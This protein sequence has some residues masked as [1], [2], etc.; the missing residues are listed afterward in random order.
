MNNKVKNNINNNNEDGEIFLQ[1][2]TYV[3][4][5]SKTKSFNSSKNDI[6]LPTSNKADMTSDSRL[7][8][9][10][11]SNQ[12]R[13]DSDFQNRNTALEGAKRYDKPVS[14]NPFRKSSDDDW[15]SKTDLNPM[16]MKDGI[17]PDTIDSNKGVKN[18]DNVL[19]NINGGNNFSKNNN[20]NSKDGLSDRFN[21]L[22][23]NNNFN[24]FDKNDNLSNDNSSSSGSNLDNKP[25][26]NDI[27]KS[28]DSKNKPNANN[29]V[30][31]LQN[32][33]AKEALKK[34]A[35]AVN[36]ALGAIANTKVGD[37]LMDV[38]LNKAKKNL[39]N[40]NGF[41]INNLI[42]GSGNKDSDE[43]EKK[44]NA[45]SGSFVG[46][47]VLTKKQKITLLTFAGTF[48]LIM[49]AVLLI[50]CIFQFDSVKTAMQASGGMD[51][52][53]NESSNN[54]SSNSTS[55]GASGSSSTTVDNDSDYSDQGLKDLSPTGNA[56]IDKI[57][58]L[59]MKQLGNGPEKYSSNYDNWCADFVCWLFKKVEGADKLLIPASSA[60]PIPRES[61]PRGLGTWIEDECTD[62]NAV[63]KAGDI[64]HWKEADPAFKVDKYSSKHVGYVYKVDDD[65][66]YTV[67]GNGG[68]YYVSTYKKSRKD[69]NI[70]GY[71]RPYY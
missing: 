8:D 11:L 58:Q 61:I 49:M 69:C 6:D 40:L 13:G 60:G 15:T 65:Y 35:V 33:A 16:D 17:V 34:G 9:T 10:Q 48:F 3:T 54:S 30:N 68:N 7:R 39:P 5:N 2:K 21:S 42:N 26:I 28:G 32:K 4:T 18:A 51:F 29:N 70:N 24:S 25:G 14:N 19:S 64:L 41:P 55:S 46:A 27:G 44:K 38:A 31:N 43:E 37:K 20:T 45:R 22:R 36:P 59:A 12:L 62:P 71:Y 66:I 67:E 53:S 57:N 47:I 52:G 1:R 23:G 63:P 56:T 50:L